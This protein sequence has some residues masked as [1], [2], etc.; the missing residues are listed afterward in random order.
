MNHFEGQFLE[1]E[2]SSGY[3]VRRM[4]LAGAVDEDAVAISFLHTPRAAFLK[5]MKEPLHGVGNY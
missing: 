4:R 2:R 5:F 3:F 1:M